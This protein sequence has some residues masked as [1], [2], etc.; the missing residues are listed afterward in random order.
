MKVV[1]LAGGYGT[2]L[3]E[4]TDLRPKP[5]VEIG[6]RPVLWHLMKYYAHFGHRDFVVCL[7]YKG[8]VVKEYFANYR[9][10]NSDLTIDVASDTIEYHSRH[11]EDWRVTLVDTGVDTMTGGR[12]KRVRR[13]LD[14]APFHLTYGDGLGAVDLDALVASHRSH[15]RL[16]TVTSVQ[17]PGRFGV[18]EIGDGE[19]V[20][21]F[22]EKP[23]AGGGWINAGFFVMQPAALDYVDGDDTT[24]EG[25]PLAR[26]ARDGELMTYRHH[27]F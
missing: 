17:P 24:L 14:D 6:G 2:R 3:S 26:L 27:G 13:F 15:G 16:V 21:D 10:H 4:E 5:M 1:I 22:H 19:A 20:I 8:F 25:A 11:S 7:G 23:V 12:V 18:L 9:L